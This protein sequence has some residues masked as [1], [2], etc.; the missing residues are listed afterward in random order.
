MPHVIALEVLHQFGGS[1]SRF[2]ILVKQIHSGTAEAERVWL[3]KS[4]MDMFFMDLELVELYGP[5]YS[6]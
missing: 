3:R 2:M 1:G 5:T 6:S 4:N